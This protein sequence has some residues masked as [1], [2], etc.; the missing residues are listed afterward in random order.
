MADDVPSPNT[1]VVQ[2]QTN[3]EMVETTAATT[4]H[5][6]VVNA[7]QEVAQAAG[8]VASGASDAIPENLPSNGATLAPDSQLAAGMSTPTHGISFVEPVPRPRPGIAFIEPAAAKPPVVPIVPG[9]LA[10]VGPA[11]P[12]TAV[13]P[14][15]EELAKLAEA[16][17]KVKSLDI[18]SLCRSRPIGK[19]P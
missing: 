7:P 12:E 9:E 8:P 13:G 4:N 16:K 2:G 17:E 5:Q 3:I 10:V 11:K 19:R 15:P 6:L 1:A 18:V 14:T